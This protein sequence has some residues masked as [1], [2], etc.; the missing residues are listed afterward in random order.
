M[1]ITTLNTIVI[2]V[3]IIAI[4]TIN[5]ITNYKQTHKNNNNLII[6]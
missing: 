4:T 1:L 3:I 2:K 5:S 6:N